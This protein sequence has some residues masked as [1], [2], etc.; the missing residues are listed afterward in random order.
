MTKSSV[1]VKFVSTIHPN[2]RDGLLRSD[3][4]NL[5]SGESIFHKSIHQYYESRS[6]VC[7][8]GVNYKEEE[9]KP[10]YWDNI[11]LA[12]FH[13]LYD[14]VYKSKS[15]L[16]KYHIP[17]RNGKAT[18]EEEKKEVSCAITLIIKMMKTLS[19]VY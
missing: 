18:L 1:K 9:T 4:A 5:E 8:Q 17:L 13:S 7:V 12:E 19:M 2:Y 15:E 10:S 11:T 3:V 16:K 14:I 6:L